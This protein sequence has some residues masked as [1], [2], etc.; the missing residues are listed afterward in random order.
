MHMQ[1]EVPCF[2]YAMNDKQYFI[3]GKEAMHINDIFNW[4]S[5]F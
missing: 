4:S 1:Y 5:L 3:A 2:Y